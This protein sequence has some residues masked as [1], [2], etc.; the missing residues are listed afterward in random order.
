LQTNRPPIRDYTKFAL[1]PHLGIVAY[2]HSGS[3]M[4]MTIDLCPL[5]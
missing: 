3:Y 4:H 5:V 1:D 2:P